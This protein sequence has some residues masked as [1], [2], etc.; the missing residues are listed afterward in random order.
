[1]TM[2]ADTFLGRLVAALARSTA[3]FRPAHEFVDPRIDP[4]TGVLTAGNWS[5]AVFDELARAARSGSP[6]GLLLIDLDHFKSLNDTW[7]HGTG[8][9]VLRTVAQLLRAAAG[10]DSLVG[11]YGGEEFVALLPTSDT[12]ASVAIADQIRTRIAQMSVPI[13]GERG[14]ALIVSD[15]TVS[16]GVAS[17]PQHGETLDELLAAADEALHHAKAGGRDQVRA[18][19]DGGESTGADAPPR[20]A[21]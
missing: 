19:G 5:N 13:T 17:R 2:R 6:S 16:I 14:E 15:Q 11:R 8:D 1:M 10:P 18:A 20:Q 12:Q 9:A 21:R 3:A 7:G 4:K